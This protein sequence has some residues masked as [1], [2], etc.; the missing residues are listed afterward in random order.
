MLINFYTFRLNSLP[1]HAFMNIGFSFLRPSRFTVFAIM[2]LFATACKDKKEFNQ[3]TAQST[4]DL[5]SA[6]GEMDE[7]LKDV[8]TVILEQYTLRGRSAGQSPTTSVCGVKLD[9]NNQLRGEISLIYDGTDCYGRI[10]TGKVTVKVVDYPSRKWKHKDCE[11]R[12]DFLAYQVSR[13]TDSKIVKIEGQQTLRNESGN[14]WFELWYMGSPPV[15]YVHSAENT[16]LTFTGNN[17]AVFNIHRSLN[18]SY[19]NEVTSCRVEGRGSS[20]GRSNVEAWG[21]STAGNTFAAEVVTPYVWRTKCGALAP[22]SGNVVV[23]LEEREYELKCK[24]GVDA[25][26]N[27]V[28]EGGSCPFGWEVTWSRKKK[29]NSRLFGYY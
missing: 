21:Q 3:E 1:V 24:Y 10:K 25:S 16:K 15:T 13:T 19:A 6:I 11:L 28:A 12:I 14:S 17:T 23:S 26:G 2:V 29:T 22:L 7:V 9:T 4:V 8:N 20:L 5:R 27:L 18:F